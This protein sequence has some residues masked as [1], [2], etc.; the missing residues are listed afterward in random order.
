MSKNAFKSMKLGIIF[1]LTRYI[2]FYKK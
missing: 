2:H 1:Y